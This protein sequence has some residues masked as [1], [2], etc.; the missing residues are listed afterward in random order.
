MK[1]AQN[2]DGLMC[3]IKREHYNWNIGTVGN[4]VKATANIF[5]LFASTFGRHANPDFFFVQS[6]QYLEY[7]LVEN[8]ALQELPQSSLT[9]A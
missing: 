2:M 8:V 4:M 5:G 6:Q 1:H 7:V 3:I 9:V